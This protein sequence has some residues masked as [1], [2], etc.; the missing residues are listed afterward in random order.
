M[1]IIPCAFAT[2]MLIVLSTLQSQ[3]Q[4]GFRSIDAASFH[5][6]LDAEPSAILVDVRTLD[7]YN[8]GHIPGAVHIDVL[9]SDFQAKVQQLDLTQPI[10]VYCHSGG[11]SARAAS[12][13]RNMDVIQIYNLRG[14]IM[15]WKANS[16]P[17]E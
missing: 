15:A 8:E 1:K 10:Y 9:Q 11:R 14:G 3:A 7:E 4:S 5:R 2:M 13:I 17:V 12:M 16:F 6:Q